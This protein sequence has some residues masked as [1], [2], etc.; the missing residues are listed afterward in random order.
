MLSVIMGQPQKVD[1]VLNINR[2]NSISI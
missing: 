1:D 2:K